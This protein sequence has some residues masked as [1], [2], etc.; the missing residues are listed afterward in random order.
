MSNVESDAGIENENLFRALFCA[1][2]AL[3][4]VLF[5]N[6]F[7]MSPGVVLFKVIYVLMALFFTL[8]TLA[9]AA[10]YTNEL[11]EGKTDKFIKNDNLF[12]AI[13]FTPLA[14]V[15]WFF[16]VNS[17]MSSGHIVFNAIYILLAL[18][19]T[20][21]TLAYAAYY[22]NDCYADNAHSA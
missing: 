3:L 14:V 20:L 16:A 13:I 17:I 22:T 12:K 8:S 15:F 7:L 21:S 19:S 4:L 6:S 9:Y 10:Y 5:A 11:Y 18:Y 1:P 2:T